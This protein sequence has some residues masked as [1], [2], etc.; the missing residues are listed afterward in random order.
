MH[1]V[2]RVSSKARRVASQ[3]RTNRPRSVETLRISIAAPALDTR[4][5]IKSIFILLHLFSPTWCYHTYIQ[6][7][8][9]F[10]YYTL[11]THAHNARTHTHNRLPLSRPFRV[12]PIPQVNLQVAMSDTLDPTY[13]TSKFLPSEIRLSRQASPLPSIKVL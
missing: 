11:Q 2:V 8:L 12:Q 10:N 4:M 6:I 7:W 9:Q 1:H 3:L 13:T 5:F